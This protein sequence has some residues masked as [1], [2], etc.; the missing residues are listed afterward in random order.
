[1]TPNQAAKKLTQEIIDE[2]M[3]PR[4][5]SFIPIYNK[6]IMMGGV[7][8][9]LGRNVTTRSKPVVKLDKNGKV[10]T[11][12]PSMADAARKNNV[13]LANI[14]RAVTKDKTSAGFRWRLVDSNDHYVYR[15][16]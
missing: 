1:M 12:Y 14:S 2:L 8:F 15:K 11:V 5:T 10:H 7:G 9:D 16:K 3:L 6:M 4:T 13:G